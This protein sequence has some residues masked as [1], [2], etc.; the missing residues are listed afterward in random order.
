[1]RARR[2]FRGWPGW[3]LASGLAVVGAGAARAGLPFETVAQGAHSRLTDAL[4]VVVRT[5]DEWTALWARHAGPG[6]PPPAVDFAR[7]MIVAV[8]AG[9]RPTSGYG[10]EITGVHVVDQE[11]QVVYQERTPAAGAIS[12]PVVTTPFHVIRIPRSELTVRVLHS[13]A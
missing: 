6:P 11:I 5:A 12:L 4:D 3:A 1:M 7:Q 9:R 10:I 2:L 13:P 8:F